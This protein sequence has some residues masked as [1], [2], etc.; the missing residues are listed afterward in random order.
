MNFTTKDPLYS[1]TSL[2]RELKS[3]VEGKFRFV[4]VQGEISNLKRPFSG[5]SYFTLKDD[6]AQLKGVLFKGSARYLKQDLTDGQQVVC[7][8]RLSIY[9]PR[10]DYQLIVDSVDFKGTGLLQQRFEQLKNKLAA[11]GLF[12]ADR[13]KQ[14][15]AFPQKIILLT[16]PSGAAVHDFLK[17]WRN[18]GYPVNI[19]IFP[20]RV[21]GAEAAA[22][23]VTALM[24]VNR[25]YADSDMVVLCRGGGSLED[26]WPF[27]EEILARAIAR[28]ALPVTSAIGH[29]I[30][31]TI[32]DFCADHR[33][34][35]PTAA[36]ETLIPDKK[37]LIEQLQRF[38]NSLSSS[39]YS[40]LE[41]YQNRVD[42]NRRLLGDMDFLFT[43]VS[44][45]LDHSTEKLHA[46]I[47]KKIEDCQI[48][49]KNLAARLHNNS[50]AAR[51]NLQQQQLTFLTEKLHFHMQNSVQDWQ[52]KLEQQSALLD[53][54]SPLATLARG[55]SI[56]RKIDP[57]TGKR[58]VLHR[59]NVLQKGDQVEVLL[60][61]G[62][63]ECRVDKVLDD[64][65]R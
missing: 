64:E 6:S 18:R 37:Q 29:E 65:K 32:S 41:N 53:A 54:V 44:L 23:I 2:T 4:R 48:T 45:R 63:F 11:E 26:L 34:A 10:G 30:D 15:P 9:E 27:N 46:V 38:S 13:K 16:S 62:I 50:P 40:Q 21:Q 8:G 20:V 7:H 57:A 24:T 47:S 19:V 1:V 56:S 52:T 49:T 36:A 35:T 14:L 31:F 33:A 17:I 60:H 55:Y 3:L 25:E 39:L 58:T 12:S 51:L 22:E 59:S 28:S 43:N 42:Q 5:H 61:R